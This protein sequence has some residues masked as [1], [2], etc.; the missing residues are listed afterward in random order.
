MNKLKAPTIWLIFHRWSSC[1][2]WW[3]F[4]TVLG[5]H[6]WQVFHITHRLPETIFRIGS[7]RVTW[8]IT[9]HLIAKSGRIVLDIYVTG[10]PC[11]SQNYTLTFW[12][13]FLL[14]TKFRNNNVIRDIASNWCLIAIISDAKLCSHR[15]VSY[16]TSLG[17]FYTN[18]T[19]GHLVAAIL[20]FANRMVG[21]L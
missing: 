6:P 13:T 14:M 1:K 16:I 8:N 9:K 5:S 12:S 3:M 11:L 19:E 20:I 17:P 15:L 18:G 10:S 21:T 7:A 4:S 2:S